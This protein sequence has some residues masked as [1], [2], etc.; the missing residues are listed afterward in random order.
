[1]RWEAQNESECGLN[2]DIS[3]IRGWVGGGPANICVGSPAMPTVN[4]HAKATVADS[5]KTCIL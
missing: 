4:I 3:T 5:N 1:M 2:I